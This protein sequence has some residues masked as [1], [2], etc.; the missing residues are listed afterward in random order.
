MFINKMIYFI[1]CI[2]GYIL[3]ITKLISY[4]GTRKLKSQHLTPIFVLQ[5][6]F[7][8]LKHAHINSKDFFVPKHTQLK[9]IPPPY[10][11]L[12]LNKN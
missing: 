6:N 8:N 12:T 5:I 1:Y 2:M 4:L 11:T 9:T 7:V 3:F 10:N